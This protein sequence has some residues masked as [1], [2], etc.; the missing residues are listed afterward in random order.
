VEGAESGLAQTLSRR[1]QEWTGERW[2]VALVGGSS[3][4]TLRETSQAREAERTSN[5]ASHPL[6]QKVLDRFKGARIVDV[7][8]PDAPS[9]PDAPRPAADEVDDEV[10]Y[11]DLSAGP[12]DEV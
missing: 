2:M 6:V 11:A 10:G 4:P 3:A 1:L 9:P 8:R 7:R 5:A 12:A